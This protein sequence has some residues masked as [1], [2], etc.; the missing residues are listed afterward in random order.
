MAL[1]TLQGAEVP[2]SNP[3]F[4]L[5]MCSSPD[6]IR[7]APSRPL[8]PLYIKYSGHET[9]VHP[10]QQASAQDIFTWFRRAGPLVS[11]RVNEDLGWPHPTCVL[12][13]WQ[14]PHA[15]YARLNCNTLHPA[16]GGMPPFALRVY[17]P[18]NLYCA[19]GSRWFVLEIRTQ[20][21]FIGTGCAFHQCHTLGGV[22]EG[23]SSFLFYMLV[24]TANSSSGK[25]LSTYH[26]DR[27]SV[28]LTASFA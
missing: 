2:G 23:M 16:L 1:A 28:C 18:R 27:L 8:S 26:F 11:V 15:Q 25:L 22:Q 5:E 21:C 14:I 10:T 17:H 12:Q 19:V 24:V 20:R 7:A 6:S 9:Q 13:Y 3:P 4:F